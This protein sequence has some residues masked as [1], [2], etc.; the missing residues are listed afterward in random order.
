M[1]VSLS[2]HRGMAPKSAARARRQI[3]VRK[4]V[5]GAPQRPRL[6]V[7][8][9]ARHISAQ[10]VDDTQGRTLASASTMEA[11]L[12]LAAAP[13]WWKPRQAYA[14]ACRR[15]PERRYAVRSESPPVADAG[16][17]QRPSYVRG[18]AAAHVRRSSAPFPC[19]G[20][21]KPPWSL[22]SLS[23]LATNPLARVADAFA[24]V[25]LGL[26]D[27]ADVCRNLS[28]TL[29]VDAE[30]GEPGRG[31]DVEGDAIRCRHLDGMAVPERKLQLSRAS[32]DHAV[33]DSNDLQ[34]LLVT[35][36]HTRHHVRNQRACQPVQRLAHSLIVGPSDLQLTVLGARDLDRL[37]DAMLERALGP[38]Y[39][40]QLTVD[41]YLDAAGD[42][43]WHPANA[44][45]FSTSSLPYSPHVG[46]DFA[47]HAV[48]VSLLVGQQTLGRRDDRDTKT[49][50][51]L[52]KSTR[53]GVHP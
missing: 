49:A 42:W 43:D 36:R 33:A 30:Y 3:R 17:H 48:V 9:S 26:A 41:S 44:R 50:E 32:G 29:L 6:V 19:V 25:R 22:T 5:F 46:D 14:P 1:A 53:L 45:H 40:D 52:G 8:G 7:T 38:Q 23:N 21:A 11:P 4:K 13:P 2:Q 35:S 37:S 15:R 28:N 16:G 12:R 20:T 27:L 10:V 18:F 34:L 39:L 47:A 31:L 51:H 24:L